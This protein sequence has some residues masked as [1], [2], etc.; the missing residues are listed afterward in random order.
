[1]MVSLTHFCLLFA[2]NDFEG[3]CYC[4]FY[5]SLFL[6]EFLFRKYF[7]FLFS[8]PFFLDFD[9]SEDEEELPAPVA[10]N[11]ECCFQLCFWLLVNLLV[12]NLLLLLT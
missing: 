6:H 8:P 5:L 10:E 4:K 7:L 11:G 12:E 1:M 9:D 3:E 2:T